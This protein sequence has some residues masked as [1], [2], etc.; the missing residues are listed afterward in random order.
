MSSLYIPNYRQ[1][2]SLSTDLRT[3]GL[4]SLIDRM[5]SIDLTPMLA[6][7]VETV[8]ASVLPYLA[9]QFNLTESWWSDLAETTDPR[10]LLLQVIP[11][12][13]KRGTPVSVIGL[14]N[15][16]GW[17]I[18]DL[19][20]GQQA[21]G[22]SSWPD[23]QGWAVFRT[24]VLKATVTGLVAPASF[25]VG[26]GIDEIIDWD[27]LFTGTVVRA[28]VMN[29]QELNAVSGTMFM[30]RQSALLDSLVFVEDMFVDTFASISDYITINGGNNIVD[31][32][33]PLTDVV[34]MPWVDL[35]DLMTNQLATFD[36]RY[37]A[38]T[39]GFTPNKQPVPR[40]VDSVITI[41]GAPV[42]GNP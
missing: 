18:V 15:G 33:Q 19:Q 12:H 13:A 17:P 10:Q 4:M 7:F 14:I 16:L 27:Y 6:Y 21:W 38:A 32:F 22:G 40:P 26:L 35:T 9:W 3:T 20:E 28:S 41:N 39:S 25:D 1:Q 24:R 30:K 23:S 11:L 42:E 34:A 31:L 37:Y 5:D 8:D 29:Q 2:T 36:G